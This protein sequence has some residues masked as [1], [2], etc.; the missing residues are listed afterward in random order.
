MLDLQVIKPHDPLW[1]QTL[2]KLRHDIYH[3]PEYLKLEAIR[4]QTIPEAILITQEDKIFLIPYLIRSCQD[5]YQN[6]PHHE[7]IFDAISPYGYPG[8][9]LSDAAF[10]QGEFLNLA[11]SY[12]AK[13]LRSKNICS[14]FFR[15][16]PIL[17][18]G[19]EQILPPQICQITG[20]TVSIN[21]MLSEAEIWQQTRSEH[22]TH[23]NRCRRAGFTAKIV[24]YE[25]Y[26]KD[27]IS[28]Y[29]ETMNRVTAKPMYYFGYDY[30]TELAN[31]HENIHLGIV[32]FDN[33]IVCASIFTEICGIVQYHLGGT[34]TEFLK[35][36]P[37]KLLF[38]RVRF[39]AK[40]RGN[41]IFQLGGGV[42]GTKD[43]LHHFKA[44]F[45]KLKHNFL[46][47][48]SIADADKYQYLVELQAKKLNVES[49][50]LLKTSFFPAYRS[51]Q[52]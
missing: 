38:D 36:S 51:S 18:Y 16:H 44:G 48:R 40:E 23:I 11:V 28:I 49:E 1:S 17:N 15:L 39:W 5:L 19:F 10:G 34:K 13:V 32:E 42:G 21:L 20:E 12:L 24:R 4:T 50:Q 45:S 2:Q 26:I 46:T 41:K 14:A 3:L 6:A 31:L 33:Q 43:S 52:I 7:E 30:F 22:R 35:Q 9:L 27:F 47:L 37:S 25:D 8:I 29:E